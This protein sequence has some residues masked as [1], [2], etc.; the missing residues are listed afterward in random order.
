M[1]THLRILFWIVVANYLAQIPYSIHLYGSALG[2]NQK[3]TLLLLATFLLFLVPY[4]LIIKK[5]HAGYFGILIFL[6]IEFLFYV[7]NFVGSILHGFPPF[8]HLSNHDPILFTAFLIGY[9][10]LFASGYFLYYL[11][12]NRS[13]YFSPAK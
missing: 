2:T 1:K 12:K 9:I 11:L 13:F 4:L 8:Y 3:G 10:N 6:T 5:S 7:W